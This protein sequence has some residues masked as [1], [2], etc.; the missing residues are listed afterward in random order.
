MIFSL[1]KKLYTSFMTIIILFIVTAVMSTILSNRIV[2]LTDQILI[3]EKRLELVLRLN[4][5]A[6]TANDNGAHYLLAPLYIEDEFKSR[7][8]SS[9][10]YVNEEIQNLDHLTSDPLS[11]QQIGQFKDNW[12]AYVK[13]TRELLLLKKQGYVR[14]AQESYTRDSF[15]PIAF[16]L[17]SFYMA[18]QEKINDYKDEIESSQEMIRTS[19]TITTSMAILLSIFIAVILSNY[20][21]ERIRLLKISAQTVAQGDLDVPDLRFK[22]KDELSELAESFNAMTS[23]LRSVIDSNQFLQRLS[24]RDGLTGIANRRCFDET[25]EREWADLTES[26]KPISLLMLD[27]DY[28][29]K[30]ND[31]YGHQAGD[32]VLKQVAYLLQEQTDGNRQLAARYGGEEFTVLLPEQSAEEALKL[33]EHFQSALEEYSIP[34]KGSKVSSIITVSIGVATIIASPSENTATLVSQADQALY[35]A[36]RTGKNRVCKYDSEDNHPRTTHKEDL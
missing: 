12:S 24:A 22:G 16:S 13:D 31:L 25:L 7:F 32:A 23:A 27:I 18:E 9:V 15:D 36:K 5:F 17:H 34:H 30:F 21:I 1:R 29:K 2:N 28:F 19:N 8:E 3:S 10:L 33:A 11:K 26:G 6:R 35:A 14:E 20:L 4:L